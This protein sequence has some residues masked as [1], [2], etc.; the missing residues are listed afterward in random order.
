M[1][2]NTVE[3]LK[4]R[5]LE[6]SYLVIYVIP[7]E[8]YIEESVNYIVKK[9]AYIMFGCTL[10]GCRKYIG[11]KMEEEMEKASDCY[12]Y[13]QEM[14]KRKTEKIIFG[15]IPNKRGIKEGLKLA[16]PEIEI[17]EAWDETIEKL[18]KYKAYRGKE[19]ILNQVKRLYMS[20]DE[21]EYEIN[22]RCFEEEY[23][24][25]PFIMD[26]VGAGLKRADNKCKY[27]KRVRK[28]IYSFNYVV[29]L[30][31]RLSVYTHERTYKTISEFEKR[32]VGYV[33]AC[34][35]QR[36]FL[37]EEW[38]MI[39]NEIYEEKKEMIRPYL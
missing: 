19:E 36:H 8:I 26:M 13:F 12:N 15:L 33:H 21:K 37:K 3:E 7:K 20:E 14:K 24:K 22:Y 16:F 28:V 18:K 27:T 9:R 34:E 11:I 38:G 10:D 35:R 2:N 17:F 31:K 6:G 5:D 32:Y 1:N 25:Y 39:I 29:E 23:R 4:K 30:K